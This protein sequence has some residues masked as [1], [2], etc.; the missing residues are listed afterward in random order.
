MA[1][2][3]PT[4]LDV[5]DRSQGYEIT[6]HGSITG[7]KAAYV[8]TDARD[9]DAGVTLIWLSDHRDQSALFDL[10]RTYERLDHDALIGLRT[11]VRFSG[12]SAV[13]IGKEDGALL[14][15][16]TLD[17]WL[18]RSAPIGL[19]PAAKLF[20][21]VLEALKALHDQGLAHGR[22]STSQML[23]TGDGTLRLMAPWVAHGADPQTHYKQAQAPELISGEMPSPVSDIYSIAVLIYL[24][25]AGKAPPSADERLTAQAQR[26]ED[27]YVP[28]AD[29]ATAVNFEVTSQLDT[30]LRLHPATRPQSMDA[31][32]DL[33]RPHAEAADHEAIPE[34]SS[35]PPM[36]TAGPWSSSKA[37][38][39]ATPPPLP[40]VKAPR[41]GQV[42]PIPRKKHTSTI[43]EAPPSRPS[44]GR[45][46]RKRKIGVG[47]VLSFALALGVAWL[48]ASGDL[49]S[50]ER[51]GREQPPPTGEPREVNRT[52][53]LEVDDAPRK[54]PRAQQ[55]D[56]D[57]GSEDTALNSVD[58][59]LEQFC[60]SRF[61]YQT[62]RDGGT[63]ALRAYLQRCQN[64]D[65][66]YVDDARDALGID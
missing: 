46:A 22:L 50:D 2:E 30:A 51:S 52:E 66:D 27:P 6:G 45:T 31:L 26:D 5:G 9:H 25:I 60:N 53:P 63:N 38:S 39:G 44:S 20:L 16:E 23:V 42:P 48:V 17:V 8:G 14:S 11:V 65:S 15:G 3:T 55:R 13:V 18:K 41:S 29:A 10:A 37:G 35:V 49:F 40:Q 4:G 28:L 24:A 56:D 33:L 12:G 61:T 57:S 43:G 32:I 36:P 19:R 58:G 7:L 1:E 54:G 59:V 62:A 64:V 21:P 47:T 34:T